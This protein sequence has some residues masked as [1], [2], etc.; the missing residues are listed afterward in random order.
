[1][2]E[3]LPVNDVYDPELGSRDLFEEQANVTAIMDIAFIEN[4]LNEEETETVYADDGSY[5]GEL[6]DLEQY[7]DLAKQEPLLSPEEEVVLAKLVE[8]G[9][10]GAKDQMIRSNLR[11]VIWRAARYQGNAM[12]FDD[13]VQQGNLG[14]IRAVEKY[15]YRKGVKFSSYGVWW[16]DNMI[17]IG[18]AASGSPLRMTES[19]RVLLSKMHIA[20]DSLVQ[21]LK[22]EPNEAD[23]A[24]SLGVD[25]EEVR[26]LLTKVQAPVY[27]DVDISDG[28]GTPT[29]A[30]DFIPGN[31]NTSEEGMQAAM[32]VELR[33]IILKV[34]GDNASKYMPVLIRSIVLE[35]TID[36]ISEETG[37]PTKKIKSLLAYGRK[38]LKD[39][40]SEFDHLLA[41]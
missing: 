29:S 16:I 5:K 21:Q 41:A 32:A 18:L 23:Y 39:S 31:Q 8:R 20:E 14:L 22:R 9:D 24:E 6:T 27:L 34:F 40:K 13:L 25:A 12:S 37:L 30:G 7:K 11:L 19:A 2:N 26:G 17:R 33:K 1:M 38:Q 15:D 35:Q 36:E 4:E 3:R 28:T 10:V